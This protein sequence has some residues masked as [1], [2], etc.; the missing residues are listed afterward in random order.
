M[1]ELPAPG[2]SI[3]NHQAD[4]LAARLRT[5][6]PPVRIQDGRLLLDP[7]TLAEDEIDLVRA[8]LA[9]SDRS[10]AKHDAFGREIGEDTLAGLGGGSKVKATPEPAEATWQQ[11]IDET[12]ATWEAAGRRRGGADRE[13]HP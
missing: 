6:D 8:A 13:R 11:R 1:F 9:T 10:V 7:R 4:E 2:T 3:A 12:E 5:A